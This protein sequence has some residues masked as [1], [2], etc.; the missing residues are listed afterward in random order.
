MAAGL[1]ILTSDVQGIPDY[2]VAGVTGFLYRPDD[3]D[4]YAEGIR[5]LYEDRQLVRT[6][7]ENNIKAV[8]KYDIENVNI[9][10]NKIYSKF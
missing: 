3:V 4:G 2:S 1:P 8:K 7:G 5:T 9:I 10:M 6:F